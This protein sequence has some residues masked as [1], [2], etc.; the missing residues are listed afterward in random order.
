MVKKLKITRTVVRITET[1][2][3]DGYYPGMT[4][5]QAIN[6]EKDPDNNEWMECFFEDK[7][8]VTTTVEVIDD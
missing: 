3:N 7:V 2:F 8:D 1:P 5:E 4:V 6:D